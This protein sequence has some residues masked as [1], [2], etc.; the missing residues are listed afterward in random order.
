VVGARERRWL[1]RAVP[2]VMRLL[3]GGEGWGVVRGV[4]G[5]MRGDGDGVDGNGEGEG[6]VVD[7]MELFGKG[8]S[9][10]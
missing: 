8:L 6:L 9:E 4:L 2:V 1:G 5:G 7:A 3:A 10:V